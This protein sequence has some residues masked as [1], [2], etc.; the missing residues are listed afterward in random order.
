MMLSANDIKQF[1]EQG[2]DQIGQPCTSVLVA[3]D[4][5]QH[6]EAIVVNAAFE[7]IS[8]VKQ[9]QMVYQ[10]L[11]S[12][13]HREIHALSMRTMTPKEFESVKNNH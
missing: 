1:I 4:D 5:G 3:G 10:V 6:F 8:L 13:M 11:G 12:K 9:H 2:F 7:G